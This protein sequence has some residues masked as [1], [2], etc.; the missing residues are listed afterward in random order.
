MNGISRRQFNALAA[1]G[2][3]VAV[4][5]GSGEVEAGKSTVIFPFGV[6]IYREPSL[7]MEQ[8][9]ADIPILKRLGFN[10]IKLQEVWAYDERRE[11]EI[12]LDKVERLIAGAQQHGIKIYFG[13]TMENA[14][15]WLWRKFPDATMLYEDGS[16][17]LDPTQY[18]LAADG[19]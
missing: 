17:H 19:N 16:P 4:F 9:L 7:P 15:A 6:H 1:A 3:A 11:G 10:M 18:V 12:N 13:F 5:G 2:A 8:L 14:P